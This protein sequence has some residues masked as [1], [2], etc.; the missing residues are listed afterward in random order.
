MGF[1]SINRMETKEFCGAAWPSNCATSKTAGSKEPTV[2]R[3]CTTD[4]GG[5]LEPTCRSWTQTTFR[6]CALRSVVVNGEGKGPTK[7]WV[8]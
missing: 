6:C 3:N 8:R 1:E 5:P 7:D 4:E 2:L